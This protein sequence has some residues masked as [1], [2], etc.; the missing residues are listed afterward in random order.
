MIGQKLSHYRFTDRISEGGMGTVYKAEDFALER[1]VAI[2]MI[3]P[4]HQDPVIATKRFLREAQAISRIDHPNVVTVYEI[5]QKGD[6]SFL[7]MQYVEGQSLRACLSKRQMDPG[8]ALRIAS[9]IAAGL[10]AAHQIGVVHRDVKPENII[11][12]PSGRPK[13]LDFGVARLIDRSTLTR[14]GKI[15]G[16]LPYMSPE[17]VKGSPVDARSD[18]YSLGVVLYEMLSGMV[19][20]DDKE[21]AALFFK[22]INVKPG[23]V[24]THVPGLSPGVDRILAKALAKDPD[25]RYQTAAE[26]GQDIVAA[27]E[28]PETVSPAKSILGKRWVIVCAAAALTI[29]AFL[30]WKL[31]ISN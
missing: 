19:P 2:K 11:I 28:L 12:E 4:S 3:K 14:K 27:S 6:A 1:T 20:L 26:M 7:I 24:S 15:V 31:L 30:L 22:V 5:I 18:V 9:E 16:T 23:P 17:S 21:E 8:T 10:E 13:V 25:R 29:A